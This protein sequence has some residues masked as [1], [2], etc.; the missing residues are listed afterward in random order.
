MKRFKGSIVIGDPSYFIKCEED[1]ERCEYGSNLAVLGFTD[2][3][4]LDFP[5]DPQIVINSDTG[6]VLGG[7]CQDSCTVA[8]V[9]KSELEKYNPDYEKDFGQAYGLDNNRAVI[10]NFDGEIDCK[11]VP[12]ETEFCGDLETV[13]DTVI[14]GT[15]NIN[16]RS[17]YEEDLS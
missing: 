12:V 10:E 2:Y 9:Y 14:T 6:E 3:L 4:Y 1:W 13:I 7:I 11:K 17:C 15:G 8:V 16:F 5:D